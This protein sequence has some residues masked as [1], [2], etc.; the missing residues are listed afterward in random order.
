MLVHFDAY[1]VIILMKFC[2][3]FAGNE[4]GKTIARGQLTMCMVVLLC[5]EGMH[6]TRARPS[7]L[8]NCTSRRSLCKW[9]CVYPS[10]VDM[11]SLEFCN[12]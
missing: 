6:D 4:Q 7:A 8:C 1:I 5:S 12:N 11:Y 2:V 9:L 10:L 3:F